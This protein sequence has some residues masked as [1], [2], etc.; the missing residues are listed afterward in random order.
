M[1]DFNMFNTLFVYWQKIKIKFNKIFP[2]LCSFLLIINF[3]LPVYAVDVFTDYKTWVEDPDTSTSKW[4]EGTSSTNGNV[5][6]SLDINVTNET[7]N[8]YS[9]GGSTGYNAGLFV[10][11]ILCSVGDV[12]SFTVTSPISSYFIGYG[13]KIEYSSSGLRSYT[14]DY[15]TDTGKAKS[16][17][18]LKEF[19]GT[20]DISFT[21]EEDGYFYFYAY[22]GKDTSGRKLDV[23]FSNISINGDVITNLSPEDILNNGNAETDS[24]VGSANDSLSNLNDIVSSYNGIEDTMLDNFIQYQGDVL[25]DLQSW[26]WG[27]LSLCANWVGDTLTSYYL[28]MGDFKQYIIYPLL[29]GIALFFIGRG[30]AIIGHLYRKPTVITTISNRE[31]ITYKNNGVKYTDSKTTIHRDGGVFRK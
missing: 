19:S 6:V 22:V 29:L 16:Y 7:V 1:G 5:K 14:T 30:S 27:G 18:T 2:I 10:P 31:S 24:I 11:N 9:A 21:L 4:K 25:T 28:N 8:F 3:S 23:T 20:E 15:V 12:I 17:G 13:S 26:S